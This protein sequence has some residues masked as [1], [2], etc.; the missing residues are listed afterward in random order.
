MAAIAACQQ[1]DDFERAVGL[2]N[3]M[4]NKVCNAST[5]ILSLLVTVVSALLST[6]K[7]ARHLAVSPRM[8]ISGNV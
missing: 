7:Y 2:L 5:A 8:L 6:A 4:R 1:D 3:H